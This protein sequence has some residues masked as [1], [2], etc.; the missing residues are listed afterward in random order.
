MSVFVLNT[1]EVPPGKLS[2][3]SSTR[4]ADSLSNERTEGRSFAEL[5]AYCS[6]T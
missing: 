4:L 5:V 2:G 3:Q 1:V 6:F